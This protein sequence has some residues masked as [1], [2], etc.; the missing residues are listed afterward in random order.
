MALLVAW[1]AWAEWICNSTR[2]ESFPRKR[3]STAVWKGARKG[4]FL[5]YTARMRILVAEDDAIL[6]EGVMTSLRNSG[7]AVDWVRNGVEADTALETDQFDLLILDLGL[8]RKPGLDVLKRL[9]Q[10]ESRLPVLV[11]PW[12]ALALSLAAPLARSPVAVLLPLEPRA[13]APCGLAC[14]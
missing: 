2:V 14:A 12:S 13:A 7:H 8:P 10:R 1:A 11:R 3:E 4:P 5:L 9:R 6:A